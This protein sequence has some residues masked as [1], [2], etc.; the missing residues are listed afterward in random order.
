MEN[1]NTWKIIASCVGLKGS[2][3]SRLVFV[4]QL[5]IPDVDAEFLSRKSRMDAFFS[6]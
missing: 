4:F 1:W 5:Q 3:T 6:V 2:M